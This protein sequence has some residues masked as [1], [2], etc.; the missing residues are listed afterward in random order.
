M[1]TA[2]TSPVKTVYFPFRWTNPKYSIEAA[3]RIYGVRSSRDSDTFFKKNTALLFYR[4][5]RLAGVN[6]IINH[7]DYR[8][9]SK[10]VIEELKEFREVNLFLRGIFPS[11]G[12]KSTEVYY[13]RGK[14]IAGETKYPLKKMLAFA[15]EGVTSFSV[16]PMRMVTLVG[17]FVFAF[18][19]IMSLWSLWA[20]FFSRVVP[21]WASIVVP[22]Y[23][24]GGVQLLSIGIIGE[25]I[26]KVYKEVKAR[27]RYIKELELS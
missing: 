13:K 11:L 25:Y 15:F 8:L 14:R 7:A 4:L 1:S 16:T 5:M 17:A 3:T 21:G 19:L 12:F 23:F 20:V 18:S 24:L 22:I 6:I 26:G 9:T 10:R 27:P 2:S